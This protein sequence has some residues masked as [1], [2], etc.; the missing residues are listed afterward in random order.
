MKKQLYYVRTNAYD[1][2]VSIDEENYCRVLSQMEE[3]PNLVNLDDSERKEKA[4]E[5]LKKIED[6]S[7]WEEY[8]V[9]EDLDKWLDLNGDLGD[10]SEI[11]AEIES[12][13]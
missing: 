10:A 1:E 11:I 5:F 6:D 4:L 12:E 2:V 3:F 8:G 7:S 9:V 13:L